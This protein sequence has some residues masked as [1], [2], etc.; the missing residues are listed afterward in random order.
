ML[1]GWFLP[2]W[3]ENL[4]DFLEGIIPLIALGVEG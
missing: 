3:L 4:V 1:Y 2:E